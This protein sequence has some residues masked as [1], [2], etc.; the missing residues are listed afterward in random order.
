MSSCA[1][2]ST[3]I[4]KA[5]DHAE[6]ICEASGGRLTKTRR[7]VLELLW[8]THQPRKA[9]DVL[10]DLSDLDPSAKPP[11]VYRALDFLQEMGLAHK[12]ESLDAYVGCTG[13]NDHAH[14]YLICQKCGTVADI[15]D[16]SVETLLAQKAKAKKFRVQKTVVEIK[17][18]CERCYP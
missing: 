13:A 2:H 11:T 12:V 18:F 1:R 9:Y 8:Q 6:T 10:K 3:C 4:Q 17:G 7:Q 14:Q 16:E 15:H 5:I